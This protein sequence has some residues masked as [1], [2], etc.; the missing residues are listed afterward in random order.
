MVYYWNIPPIPVGNLNVTET[1]LLPDIH[2]QGHGFTC[3]GL[4]YDPINEVFLVGDIGALQPEE[5]VASQIVIMSKDFSTV[6]G[7]IPL[8]TTMPNM[9]GVQ[10]VTVDMSDGTIWVCDSGHNQIVNVRRDASVIKTISTN[11]PT[12]I[13]YASSDDSF[14]ILSYDNNIRHVS[15]SGSVLGTYQFAY[16]EALDQCFLDEYRGLLYITA[17]TNYQSRNNV[18]Y[19]NINTQEQSIACTVDSY[20]VEGIWLG[21]GNKMVILNDGY[22]HSAA[23]NRNLVNIYTIE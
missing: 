20:S 7:I 18:Y 1:I 8:Y 4:A 10:G 9:S 13:A 11:R 12:G 19:F 16:N 15:K 5:N 21:D 14:W 22:Y 6:E 17:G 3:T 23:D 2:Q